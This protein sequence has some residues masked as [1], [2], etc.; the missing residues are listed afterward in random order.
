MHAR[1]L[2]ILLLLAGVAQAEPRRFA[3]LVG[4]NAGDPRESH[5]RYAEDEARR[6]GQILGGV[7]DFRA[8]DVVVL[9]H[10]GAAAVKQAL[11]QLRARMAELHD[12]TLLFVF[13]SGHA[14]AEALHLGD[15]R[16]P[17]A[18][19]RDTVND[20]PAT[21][22]ILV[23]DACRSGALTRV[24]GGRP[25]PGFEV[26]LDAPLGSRGFAILTSSAA[27]EDSQE[28][29][30]I[31]SSLFTHFFTSALRG[32]GD[33]NDDGQVTLEEAFG[34]ASERTILATSSTQVGPQHPTFRYDLGGRGGL[35][36]TRPGLQHASIGWIELPEPGWY[37]VRKPNGPVIAEVQSSRRGQ[38]LALE[39]G[40]YQ[41]SWRL[42]DYYMEGGM[43]VA[44]G[45]RSSLDAVQLHRYAYP[46]GLRKGLEA[47]LFPVADPGPVPLYKKW[48]LWTVVGA[49]AVGVGVGLGVGLTQTRSESTLNAISF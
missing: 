36:L 27:G 1:S 46:R 10:P 34:Y 7:G 44:A 21:A 4:A 8:E 6:L 47:A 11:E 23:V 42:T 15:D 26:R 29:D 24:K 20:V 40:A 18:E 32:A 16:L 2:L 13:Y 25:G 35:V 39:T 5:L 19:L 22:R 41:I 38:K 45:A 30:E 17:L 28:S 33:K 49:V 48:W 12:E 37:V 43:T 14:D 3:L 31:G 9:A